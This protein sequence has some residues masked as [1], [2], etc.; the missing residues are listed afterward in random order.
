MEVTN[1]KRRRI[2]ISDNVLR[3]AAGQGMDAFIRVFTDAIYESIGG[4]LT[5]ETM[6][7]L[8]SDQITLLAYAALRDEV[9]DGGFV[10]LIYNGYGAFIF[11]NPFGKAVRNW[12]LRDLY[13][14]VR[15]VRPL[16][17]MHREEIER[18]CTDEEFMALFERFSDFDEFDDD[19]VA[20]EEE[21]TEAVARYMDE[22][23]E[24]FAE[25]VV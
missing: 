7:E 11:C 8:N 22:H 10:Q 6:G 13:R 23:I 5:Q 12:G 2:K 4:R 9:M 21:W 17:F 15:K 25:I 19:F 1:E 18:E 14:L 3:D 24:N 20:C 16:Y